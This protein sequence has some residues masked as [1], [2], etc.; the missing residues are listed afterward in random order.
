VHTTKPDTGQTDSVHTT[1]PDTS[2]W[3]RAYHKAWHRSDWQC[4]HHKARHRSDWQRAHHKARHRSDWQRAHHKLCKTGKL[5]VCTRHNLLSPILFMAWQRG[6]LITRHSAILHA[7]ASTYVHLSI[8]SW[9]CSLALKCIPRD[10][11]CLVPEFP[12]LYGS[13]TIQRRARGHAA[14]CYG[15]VNFQYISMLM[16]SRWCTCS[17]TVLVLQLSK[18]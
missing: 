4:A 8:P 12:G 1:K 14:Y 2:D 15:H 6:H 10:L 17:K 18:F 9:S 16:F 11:A 13:N 7:Y 3:Q 5:T